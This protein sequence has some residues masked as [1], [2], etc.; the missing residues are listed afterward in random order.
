MVVGNLLSV[1]HATVT[2]LDGIYQM[3]VQKN[4]IMIVRK[5]RKEESRLPRRSLLRKLLKD[6]AQSMERTGDLANTGFGQ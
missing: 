1:V 2:D 6:Y 3:K 4:R 5:A